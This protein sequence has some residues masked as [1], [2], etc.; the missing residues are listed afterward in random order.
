MHGFPLPGGNGVARPASNPTPSPVSDFLCPR[1]PTN[2]LGGS[3]TLRGSRRRR[4]NPPSSFLLGAISEAPRRHRHRTPPSENRETTP[5]RRTGKPKMQKE[6]GAEWGDAGFLA[7]GHRP[8]THRRVHSHSRIVDVL[9]ARSRRPC[10]LGSRRWS[11]TPHRT[12]Q[13]KLQRRLES[14]QASLASVGCATPVFD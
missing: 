11:F 4:N 9:D 7:T 6:K 10:H 8:R 13:S 1:V 12:A 3:L 5:S 2:N 14:R